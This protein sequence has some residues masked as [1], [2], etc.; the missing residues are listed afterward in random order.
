ESLSPQRLSEWAIWW[1]SPVGGASRARRRKPLSPQQRRER[2]VQWGATTGGTCASAPAGSAASRRGGSGGGQ[3]QQQRPLETLS[4]QQLCEWAVQW[5]STGGGGFRGTPTGGVEASGGVEANSLALQ[6]HCSQPLCLSHWLTS[7]G[8]RKSLVALLF[9][10]VRRPSGLLIGLHLPLFAKNLVATSVLQD[11]WV[12]VTHLGGELVAICTDSRTGDHLATF[13]RRPGSGVYILTTE[14]ALV[15]ESGQVAA[16][17]EV[18]AS[19]LCC[20]LTH[21]NLLWHHCLGHP[22]LPRLRGMHARLLVS[23]L[24][25]SLPPLPR[26]LPPPC[27]PCVEGRQRAA[28]HSSFPPTTAP[29]Q[30]LHMDVWGPTH[31]TGQGGERYFLLVVDDYMRYT[32][33]FTLQSKADVRGVLIR[34]I[35]AVRLQLRARFCQDLP[36]LRLHSDRGGEL[37]SHLLEDFYGAEGIVQSYTLPASPQQNGIAECRIGL[38]MEVTRTSMIHAAAPRFLW[39]NSSGRSSSNG[40]GSCTGGRS[41][42]SGGFSCSACSNLHSGA[43]T[44]PASTHSGTIRLVLTFDAGSGATSPTARLSFTLDSGASNCF[45]R[46]CT[47]LTPLHTP[48]TIALADPSIGS[49]VAESTTTLPCPAAPSGFLTGYYT[50]SFSRNLVGVIHLHN[51]GV[52][53][54]FPLHKPVASCTVGATGAPLAT[55]HREPGSVCVVYGGAGGAVA[56]GEGT[57]AAVARGASSGG[58]GG[59]PPRSPLRPVAA[60]PGGVPAGG[61]KVM[62]VLLV[63]VLVLGLLEPET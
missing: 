51:L 6:S 18:A 46:D 48:V 9:S 10:P 56:E 34:W 36:I 45:L 47:D 40:S 27:L 49:V 42:S 55:F 31:V 5:G 38:I 43:L 13:T 14:S 21:Q 25:R 29:L 8:A 33:V 37:C 41:C 62:G 17:V 15:A 26:S 16:S 52:V 44:D 30:T 4:P 2:A 53:T 11:Q 19:C 63:E 59:F 60:E 58:V 57:G 39:P 3:Q 23:G 50:R 7:S 32:M 54:T 1:G 61:T 20:L 28:P 12:T 22:S 24:P 35:R